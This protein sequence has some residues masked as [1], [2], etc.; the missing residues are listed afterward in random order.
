MGAL[1]GTYF[2]ENGH[3]VSFLFH[4]QVEEEDSIKACEIC[5]S[6]NIKFDR[7]HGDSDYNYRVPTKPIKII[8]GHTCA[9]CNFYH[10]E[11]RI[12]D[13]SKLFNE[14]WEESLRPEGCKCNLNKHSKVIIQGNADDGFEWLHQCLY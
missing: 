1:G 5:K 3:F 4:H 9:L 2:C 6:T 13:V 12:Y 10:G 8:K 14:G 7:E 11:V